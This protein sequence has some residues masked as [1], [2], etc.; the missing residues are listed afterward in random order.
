[1]RMQI[2]ERSLFSYYFFRFVNQVRGDAMNLRWRLP[3]FLTLF[4]CNVSELAFVEL[5]G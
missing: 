5:G 3:S 4:F 2:S 1:V